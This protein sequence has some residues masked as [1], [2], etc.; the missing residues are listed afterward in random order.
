[1]IAC[2]YFQR[3]YNRPA[4]EKFYKAARKFETPAIENFSR[5]F[6]SIFVS[7]Q[8]HVLARCLLKVTFKYHHN[9]HNEQDRTYF[10]REYN[11]RTKNKGE[12]FETPAIE[13]FSQNF[14]D[15]C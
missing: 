14:V 9:V 10:Q 5:N 3:K 7:A 13:N 4:N 12:N 6:I 11:R 15:F 1:M 2:T 8:T